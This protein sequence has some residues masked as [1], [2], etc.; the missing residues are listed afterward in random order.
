MRNCCCTRSSFL[1]ETEERNFLGGRSEGGAIVNVLQG[2][3]RPWF[4]MQGE[5]FDKCGPVTSNTD[6]TVNVVY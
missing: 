3:N 1:C 5:D 4:I 2:L 6:S